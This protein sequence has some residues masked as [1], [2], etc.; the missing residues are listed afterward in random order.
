MT[1]SMPLT[2]PE[3]FFKSCRTK[4][5][6]TGEPVGIRR[7]RPMERAGAGNRAGHNSPGRQ[8]VGYTIGND[9]S[10]R[11]IEGEN[12]LYLPQAKIYEGA[13]AIGPGLF[14]TSEPLPRKWTIDI[15]WCGATALSSQAT[16]RSHSCDGRRAS[17]SNSCIVR[18]AFRTGASCS[19][20]QGSFRRTRSRWQRGTEFAISISGVGTL[21]NM[22]VTV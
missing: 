11:D 18:R 12:P 22:V 16:Q 2:R 9:M 5:C 17:W 7:D 10:S 15:L 13:C 4:L 8:I 6:H 1:G 3:I 14:V 21:K 20:A 19:P